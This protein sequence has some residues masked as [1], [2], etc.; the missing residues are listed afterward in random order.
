MGMGEAMHRRKLRESRATLNAAR[1][2]GVIALVASLGIAGTSCQYGATMWSDCSGAPKN[3]Q[4]GTDTDY[5]LHCEGGMWKPIMTVGEYFKILFHQ[6]VVIAPLPA[7]PTT[8][9]TVVPAPP[10]VGCY[11]KAD[12]AGDDLHF[13]GLISRH[14]ASL[15]TSTNGSC[16]GTSSAETVVFAFDLPGAFDACVALG[17]QG[18]SSQD[19]STFGNGRLVNLWACLDA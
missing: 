17:E 3:D 19:L 13:A 4:F 1:A 10:P 11:V 8:T 9:T 7:E 14:D 12:Q 16:T 2:V 5:V 15:F 18:V 6:P